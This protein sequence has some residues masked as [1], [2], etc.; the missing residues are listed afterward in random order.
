S[1]S[2]NANGTIRKNMAV[3]GSVAANDV[4]VID[5]AANGQVKTTTTASDPKVFGVATTT[6]TPQ[7]IVVSGVYQ[8]NLLATNQAITQGDFLVTTTTAGKVDKSTSPAAGTV[9]GRA[10]ESKS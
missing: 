7:D 5:T 10:L 4:V 9:L 1:A 2:G 3:G 8:V 6:T